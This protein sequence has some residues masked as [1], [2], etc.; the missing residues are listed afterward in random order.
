CSPCPD[1][2]PAHPNGPVP[3]RPRMTWRRRPF[4]CI[5]WY[6]IRFDLLGLITDPGRPAASLSIAC[7]H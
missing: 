2:A 6:Q 5:V 7:R 4:P 3:H 1:P